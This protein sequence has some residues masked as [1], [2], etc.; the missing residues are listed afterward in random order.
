M[1]RSTDQEAFWEGD[2]GNDYTE[3]NRGPRWVAANL[4]F[5]GKAL[6]HA[7]EV[8]AV[9]E[10]GPNIGLNLI[11]LR[12][13]LPEAK[14]SAVEINE[15]AASELKTNLP[16]VD[17]HLRSI[18]DF[19]P[20]RTWDL[21]FTKGVLIHISPDKLSRVYE[22]MHRSSS[23]YVLVCEYYNPNPVEVTYRGYTGKL[24]K[25]D[26]AGEM[27]EQFCD[28]SLIDYGFAYHRD[29]NCPQDDMT[30]FLMEKK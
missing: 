16:N 21:V 30:W 22:L 25:R 2:F 12:K 23:R 3:R 28:L 9:L 18:F 29:P 7:E 27:L 8:Q 19:Q 11:A 26:F 13:M 17:L 14:L 1:T 5:F 4:A 20:N 10:L 15:K 24:F 6:D